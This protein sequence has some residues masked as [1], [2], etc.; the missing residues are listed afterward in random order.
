[1]GS[2]SGCIIIIILYLLRKDHNEK[3]FKR[4]LKSEADNL[5]RKLLK[6][7]IKKG[8]N[9]DLGESFQTQVKSL[10]RSIKSVKTF[11]SALSR[12]LSGKVDNHCRDRGATFLGVNFDFDE[13]ESNEFDSE[14]GDANSVEEVEETNF[15]FE[16]IY[17][18]GNS[19]NL[20]AKVARFGKQTGRTEDSR[21]SGNGKINNPEEAKS[22][23]QFR[24]AAVV[25]E[26]LFKLYPGRSIFIKKRNLWGI[27]GVQHKYLTMFAASTVTQTR[28]IRFFN[29]LSLIL[30][31][32]FADTVFFGIFYPAHSACTSMTDKVNQIRRFWFY[33]VTSVI[34]SNPFKCT[35][36]HLYYVFL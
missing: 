4:Y 9:G 25:A 23:K 15:G 36:K 10:N 21:D 24:T 22:A 32:I 2:L 12:T 5:T 30:T 16:N 29:V 3:L 8:G 26:F 14:C 19:V 13:M 27:V 20:S 33:S 17:S 11:S 6:D 35:P 28:T 7:E 18:D 34:Y 1:M 31:S